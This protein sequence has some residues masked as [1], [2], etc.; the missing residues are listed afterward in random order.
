MRRS[1]VRWRR[2]IPR[3]QPRVGSAVTTVALVIVLVTS[4]VVPL[5]KPGSATT[6]AVIGQRRRS[7]DVPA[8]EE[9][10]TAGLT[11]PIVVTPGETCWINGT[12]VSS[13][14][15]VHGN[16]TI[17]SGG[18]LV[19]Q[20]VTISVAQSI[21]APGAGLSNQLSELS[22][23]YDGGRVNFVR[24]VLTTDT[25]VSN[26]YIKFNVT[27]TGTLSLYGS[28]FEFP[29]WINLVGSSAQFLLNESTVTSNPLVSDMN[30]PPSIT[31]DTSYA[32]DLL[33]QNGA[34]VVAFA[35]AFDNVYADNFS[36][37][38]SP[39]L[40]PIIDQSTF[41]ISP[42]TSFNL[43]DFETPSS[44]T[45]LIQ[46]FLNPVNLT[47]AYLEFNFT[48]AGSVTTNVTIG[49]DGEQ[50]DI[51]FFPLSGGTNSVAV[52]GLPPSLRAA[53]GAVGTRGLLNSTA[54]FGRSQ[55]TLTVGFLQTEVGSSTATISDP[56]FLFGA[57]VS[58][59]LT[60]EGTGTTLISADSAFDVNWNLTSLADSQGAPWQS[61]KLS[62]N[63]GA[64]ALLANLSIPTSPKTSSASAIS[65]GSGSQAITYRWAKFCATG[66]GGA[67]ANAT[68]S[69]FAASTETNTST[70]E[71]ND[72]GQLSPTL[73]NYVKWVSTEQGFGNYG[74][75][76]SSGPEEGNALLLLAADQMAHDESPVFLGNY[77]ISIDPLIP[78]MLPK[79]LTWNVTPYPEGLDRPSMDVAPVAYFPNYS[80]ALTIVADTYLVGNLPSANASIGDTVESRVEVTNIGPAASWNLSASLELEDSAIGLHAVVASIGVVTL[81]LRPMESYMLSET[82]TIAQAT[83]G[84]HG[85][86]NVSLNQSVEW[87]GGP[88]FLNGGRVFTSAPFTI[89][90]SR[91]DLTNVSGPP[92][93]LYPTKNYSVAGTIYFN[94]TG[95]ALVTLSAVPSSS[96]T[97]T[98]ALGS[99]LAASGPFS[100]EFGDL[101]PELTPGLSYHLVI[102]AAFNN[103]SS[104]EYIL[105][106][107]FSEPPSSLNISKFKLSVGAAK[108][109]SVRV[110]Q[111][112]ELSV[113]VV[114]QGAATVSNVSGTLEFS[115][116]A[117]NL[118]RLVS[119]IPL[120]V[121]HVLADG[122]L[123][124]H[125]NWTVNQTVVGLHGVEAA[126]LTLTLEW[127]G[128][129]GLVNGGAV[130]LTVQIT[131]LPSIV[132][133]LEVSAPPATL[134][135]NRNYTLPG[136]ITFN[137]TG[138]AEVSLI[139]EPGTRSGASIRLAEAA[140]DN[141]T[142][143]LKLVAPGSLLVPGVSYA[144]FVEATFNTVTSSMFSLNGTF[145]EP[146]ASLREAST[147]YIED[148][149]SSDSVRIG[150]TIWIEAVFT[151]VGV[152]YVKN[153]TES[154]LV[155]NSSL[156]LISRVL[157][158]TY[159]PVSIPHNGSLIVSTNW[160]V[161]QAAVGLRGFFNATAEII[162]EWNGG[163]VLLDGGRVVDN[164]TLGIQPSEIRL[165]DVA[166]PP[167]LLSTSQNYSSIGS[168]NFNG[169]GLATITLYAI[170]LG[171]GSPITV[172][173]ALALNGSFVLNYGLLGDLL[174]QRTLYDLVAEA[175][176]NSATSPPY[177]LPG[178]FSLVPLA[179]HSTPFPWIALITI[180][181]VCAGI[182]A[183]IFVTRTRRSRTLECSECGSTVPL[184]DTECSIC[185]TIFDRD[186][187]PCPQCRG[188]IP[189]GV[190]ACPAC[191]RT[192]AN[193]PNRPGS[194]SDRDGYHEHIEHYRDAAHGDLGDDFPEP[195]FWKW[196]RQQPA[197]QSYRD[198]LEGRPPAPQ[199]RGVVGDD[200]LGLGD[201]R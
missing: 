7:T 8:V 41:T 94:G 162:V 9:A 83:V 101:G 42:S 170:P 84:L 72:L 138:S 178:T 129:P 53:I 182:V 15:Y 102:Q 200:P 22:E 48:S 159:M 201:G 146:V 13:T 78:G 34:H 150:Q 19:I 115:D 160:T 156:G 125:M 193:R 88:A 46:D 95:P 131:I 100:I 134:Y 12:G 114:N 10:C 168:V 130:S 39:A 31:Q 194:V 56:R 186:E 23:L 140:S 3:P 149:S 137:G 21:G 59:N 67:I 152:A 141:S 74:Q 164:Q 117:I 145:S 180:V 82:W 133:V 25:N 188:T 111:T 191:S 199:G 118:S 30:L 27:V 157:S 132:R 121:V 158:P 105:P 169:S 66:P 49:F 89:R 26:P 50:F 189:A 148:G 190:A 112:L 120:T 126:N 165:I 142:F 110:G 139:A 35:S 77:T 28:S 144:L 68:V 136:K 119:T 45:D 122:A 65:L 155:V 36:A 166:A 98:I 90:P 11:Q 103:R 175:S 80:S 192:P 96:N 91:I 179:V 5:L 108:V 38:G 106:G 32:P 16:V 6:S 184:A 171:G 135:P 55:S 151:N 127:N 163:P 58:Y 143:V 4:F 75:T 51:G 1:A 14:F 37:S 109:D 153:V 29:G 63:S 154:I 128:G 62:L 116:S 113:V 185:G 57:D 167:S 176:F 172:A 87:D 197:Y 187:A 198:W 76:D 85:T 147:E 43:S 44:A 86:E 195:E 173:R 99:A 97:T 174:T 40:L 124:L 18:I 104:P 60:F 54:S 52:L 71:A 69:A 33:A 161:T 92:S 81:S 2:S 177:A 61:T 64:E 123:P 73:A 70:N 107:T 17:D 181:A 47:A 79:A 20:N 93:V 196:W 24:S 183:V